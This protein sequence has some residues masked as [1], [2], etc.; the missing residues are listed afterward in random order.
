M[1][2]KISSY[3]APLAAAA[4]LG[5]AGCSTT[6][7]N[8]YSRNELMQNQPQGIY[9]FAPNQ[10][11]AFVDMG[12]LQDDPEFYR[13]ILPE[14]ADPAIDADFEAWYFNNDPNTRLGSN[15]NLAII[16]ANTNPDLIPVLMYTQ[17]EEP[18]MD[19]LKTG[20]R[21]TQNIRY[22]FFNREELAEK[23]EQNPDSLYVSHTD[24]R[25]KADIIE[26]IAVGSVYGLASG[27]AG[28]GALVGTVYAGGKMSFRYLSQDD[29][30]D[31]ATTVSYVPDIDSL[32]AHG[33][34]GRE[35]DHETLFQA[36]NRAGR[37]MIPYVD[38]ETGIGLYVTSDNRNMANEVQVNGSL[39]DLVSGNATFEDTKVVDITTVSENHDYA[40]L[41]AVILSGVGGA[42]H[43]N[44]I[45]DANN[46]S[47]DFF[48]NG[49]GGSP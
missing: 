35:E 17:L 24:A 31:I 9:Q 42:I 33:I 36:R 32:G 47:V 29:L 41:W 22:A 34:Q 10:Q 6:T 21:N 49:P 39:E 38:T 2:K 1:N 20:T 12:V 40:A 7:S 18:S 26:G 13:S 8:S 30:E 46:G 11:R 27:N 23:L 48:N 14:G 15:T 3:V 43:G 25:Y 19:G 28:A 37:Q 4:A 16:T 5:L 45:N 44:Q